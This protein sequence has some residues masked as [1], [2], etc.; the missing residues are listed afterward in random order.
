MNTTAKGNTAIL[1]EALAWISLGPSYDETKEEAVL[2]MMRVASK[3][4]LDYDGEDNEY[5]D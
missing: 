3:A 1:I 4:L 2:E 5:L